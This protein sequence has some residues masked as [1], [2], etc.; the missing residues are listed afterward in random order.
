[1]TGALAARARHRRQRLAVPRPDGGLA[2]AAIE[3]S[4][5]WREDLGGGQAARSRLHHRQ[6]VLVVQHGGHTRH[7]RHA[8]ADLQGRRPQAAGLL[9]PAAQR[10]ATSSRANSGRFPCSSSGGR[11]HRSRRRAGSRMPHCMSGAPAAPTLTLVYLPHLDYDLQR[12][13]PDD[14]RIAK[15]LAEIDAVAGDLIADAERDGARVVVLS[16]YGITPVSTPI[17][18]NRALREAGLLRVRRRGRRRAT[19]HSAV[20]CLRGSRPSDRAHLRGQAE[21]LVE[22]VR[23]IV[24]SLAGVE[25]VLDRAEQR[26]IGL[27]HPRSG[28]LVALARPRRLVHLLLLARRSL[29]AGFRSP[30]RDP[31]QARL[32]SGRAVPRSGDPLSQACG[33]L[34]P[35]AGG[36]SAS[37]P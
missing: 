34:A 23:R 33:R 27:D 16:E 5:R 20:G 35:R 22:E 10:C 7:R 37:A 1:M 29:R 36:R 11:R 21:Q 24:A 31:S 18:I 8:A 9:H 28:E 15:S 13:G 25:Q 3:P 30:R 32:R 14:P 26:A 19:R 6:S 17:H 2:V 4:G 12:F